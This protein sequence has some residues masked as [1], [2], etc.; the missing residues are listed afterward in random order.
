[1]T[2]DDPALAPRDAAKFCGMSQRSFITIAARADGPIRTQ[3][4]D[5]KQGFR[6]SHLRAWI[7]SRAVAPKGAA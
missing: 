1:M 7:D 4:T 5:H 6:P 3:I 2:N